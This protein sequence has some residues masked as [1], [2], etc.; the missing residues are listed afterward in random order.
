MSRKQLFYV[1]NELGEA[2]PAKDVVEWMSWQQSVRSS[3]IL[4]RDVIG[5]IEVSTTFTGINYSPDDQQPPQVWET[6]IFGSQYDN[7]VSRYAT[8]EEAS[9]GHKKIVDRIKLEVKQTA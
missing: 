1:L 9:T 6:M 4:F 5:T 7:T 8:K 3:K 2:V